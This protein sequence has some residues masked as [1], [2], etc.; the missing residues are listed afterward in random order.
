G[1]TVGQIGFIDQ[2]A[3]SASVVAD[4]TV[5]AMRLDHASFHRLS[6]EHP[7]LVQ[8]LLSQ[9]SIDLATHLRASNMHALAQAHHA[10]A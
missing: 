2:Q 1:T 5:E 7:A 9:L 6:Q 8:K 4:N 3:R 10:M